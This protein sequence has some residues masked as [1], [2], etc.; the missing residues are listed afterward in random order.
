MKVLLPLVLVALVALCVLCAWRSRAV[1]ASAIG[2]GAAVRERRFTLSLAYVIY[3]MTA[4]ACIGLMMP[5]YQAADEGAHFFRAIQVGLDVPLGFRSDKNSGGVI[6]NGAVHSYWTFYPIVL[7]EERKATSQLFADADASTWHTGKEFYDFANTAFYP[8][9]FYAV[10]AAAI[11]AG[12]AA[13]LSILDTLYLARLLNGF[14]AVGLGALAIAVAGT[15]APWFFAVLCLPMSTAQAASVS[16]D[17][18]MFPAAALG[19]AIFVRFLRA[20]D[21]NGYDAALMCILLAIVATGRVA[22]GALALLPLALRGTPWVPRLLGAASILVA[23]LGWAWLAATFT[24]VQFGP[25]EANASGQIHQILAHPSTVLSVAVNTIR[26]QLDLYLESFIGKLGWLDLSLPRL[27]IEVAWAIL[28]F[29]ALASLPRVP[30]ETPDRR[31]AALTALALVSAV[32]VLF[33]ALYVSWTPVGN[34]IVD[35]IQGRYFI[36]LA[37]FL[38]ALIPF[39]SRRELLRPL[40]W[41]V[42]AFP[43][44]SVTVVVLGIVRRYYES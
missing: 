25:P 32:G 13:G 42:A 11:D 33:A 15:A 37:F 28:L 18:L 7:H 14:V 12:K 10:A 2:L 23:A 41:A 38:P 19:A 39:G 5:P 40:T 34:F 8:P 9:Y 6:D 29:A 36:P 1:R 16:Q 21:V 24:L 31:A 4:V 30:T 3:G 27:Y 26:F 44:A 43:I 22:Y 20:R 35:G 17:A